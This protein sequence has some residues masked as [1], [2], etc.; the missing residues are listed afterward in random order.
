MLREHRAD[1]SDVFN[2]INLVILG[3]MEWLEKVKR[4]PDPG[5][6]A[7]VDM[8]E[9]SQRTPTEPLWFFGCC[10]LRTCPEGTLLSHRLVGIIDIAL[11]G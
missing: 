9:T 8:V 4:D 7:E 2:S 10:A 3:I 6:E 1:I 5:Q 11:R